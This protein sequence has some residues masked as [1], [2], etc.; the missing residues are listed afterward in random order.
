MDRP[1]AIVTGAANNIG[2][3]IAEELASSYALVLV[4]RADAS[5][6]ASR[7][8]QAV[9]VKADVCNGD[10]CARA[11]AAAQ[12]LG[13][14]KAL[15]HAAGIT[16]PAVPIAELA[17]QDWEQVLRVNLT[18]S[19]VLAQAAIPALIA[20][21]PSS[22]VL[23]SSRAGKTGYAGF[24]QALSA[25]KAHYAASKAGVNSLMR[26]LAIELAGS[27]V[28]VNVVAPGAIATDMIARERWDEIG[29][30]VPLKRIGTPVDIARAARFL[31]DP[32][33]AGYITGHVLNVN[34]GTLME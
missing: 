10:D 27:G 2:R 29:A 32:D 11:V 22:V 7:L 16:Q 18:G 15:V 24:G 14:L 3:A 25:S 21:A 20:G 12:R 33:A 5:G 4:D 26:S 23:I 17:V 6:V 9:A 13:P 31:L 1:V 34:G 30:A 28:R 8:P 19:F